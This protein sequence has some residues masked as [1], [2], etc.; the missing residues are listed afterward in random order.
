MTKVLLPAGV[1]AVERAPYLTFQIADSG[2]PDP[3]LI[4]SVVALE[5]AEVVAE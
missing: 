3:E 5:P 4:A 1:N 2:E